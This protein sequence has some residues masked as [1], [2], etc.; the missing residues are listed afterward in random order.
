M[1][2][3]QMKV[4]MESYYNLH[5]QPDPDTVTTGSSFTLREDPST[6]GSKMQS[7]NTKVA[8]QKV[9]SKNAFEQ[10]E[11]PQTTKKPNRK[12]KKS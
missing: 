6:K 4:V 12:S 8:L 10:T 1:D 3:K 7:L 11:A 9:I 2:Q 5:L